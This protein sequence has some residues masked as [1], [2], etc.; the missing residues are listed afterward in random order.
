MKKKT[1]QM[2]KD[3]EQRVLILE[4]NLELLKRYEPQRQYNPY[5][6]IG[7]GL[8]PNELPAFKCKTCEMDFANMTG[9]VCPRSDCPS[10]VTFTGVNN[11]LRY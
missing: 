3:L 4:A 7:P 6:I 2:I 9:Y 8:I 5:D 10:R 1:K 11:D